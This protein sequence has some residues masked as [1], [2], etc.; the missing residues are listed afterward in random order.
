MF[1]VLELNYY[2]EEPI[3][4]IFEIVLEFMRPINANIRYLI[5]CCVLNLTLQTFNICTKFIIFNSTV[6]RS[7]EHKYCH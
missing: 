7:Q 5:C 2:L 1:N 4:I 3:N 6:K